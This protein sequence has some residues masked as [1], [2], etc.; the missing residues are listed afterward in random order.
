MWLAKQ[1]PYLIFCT[2]NVDRKCPECIHDPPP[3]PVK[4]TMKIT[5]K[6]VT[7]KVTDFV[8]PQSDKLAEVEKK[9]YPDGY[10]SGITKGNLPHRG[11]FVYKSSDNRNRKK[12]DGKFVNGTLILMWILHLYLF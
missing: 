7:D 8:S 9:S 4:D 6:K 10:F 12:Y 11:I 2:R 3:P 5:F 1:E